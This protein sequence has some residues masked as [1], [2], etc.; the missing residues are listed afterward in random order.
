[1][2]NSEILIGL[3]VIDMIR[4]KLRKEHTSEYDIL[5]RGEVEELLDEVSE[6][7]KN[8]SPEESEAATNKMLRAFFGLD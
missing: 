3:G 6:V 7:I 8:G 2:L 4:T 1:M 5:R